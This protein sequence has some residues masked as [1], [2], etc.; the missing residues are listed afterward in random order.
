MRARYKCKTQEA[1]HIIQGYTSFVVK[2]WNIQKQLCRTW[3]GFRQLI[4]FV[5]SHD[6]WMLHWKQGKTEQND[7]ILRYKPFWTNISTFHCNFNSSHQTKTN[8]IH[9]QTHSRVTQIKIDMKVSSLPMIFDTFTLIHTVH[10]SHFRS[11]IFKIVYNN[12]CTYVRWWWW[13]IGK[14]SW[15]F[16]KLF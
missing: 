8:H 15:H 5:L 10:P 7:I 14:P 13:K 16:W 9:T 11:H 6:R 4:K 12:T 1:T 2:Q 3:C